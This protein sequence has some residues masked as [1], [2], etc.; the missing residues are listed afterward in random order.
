M[1][2]PEPAPTGNPYAHADEDD[3]Q[4]IETVTTTGEYL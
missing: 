1:T 4:P 2:Q 3:E